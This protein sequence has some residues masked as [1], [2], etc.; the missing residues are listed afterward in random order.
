MLGIA[1]TAYERLCLFGG[2]LA[3]ALLPGP[4]KGAR[5]VTAALG[6]VFLFQT[7]A[8]LGIL[9]LVLALGFLGKELFRAPFLRGLALHRRGHGGRARRLLRSG[10]LRN[11]RVSAGDAAGG[12][13]AGDAGGPERKRDFDSR[14][15]APAYW[16]PS[17]GETRCP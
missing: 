8:Y 16:A 2:A 11:G 14:R 15:R 10:A 7:H 4:R 17:G 5:K 9:S 6:S 12:S 13:G 3:A 1:E